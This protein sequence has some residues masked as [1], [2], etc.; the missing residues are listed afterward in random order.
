MLGAPRL[1]RSWPRRRLLPDRERC[2]AELLLRYRAGARRLQEQQWQYVCV[3]EDGSLAATATSAFQANTTFSVIVHHEEGKVSLRSHLGTYVTAHLLFGGISA[4]GITIGRSEKFTVI[5][6][7]DGELAFQSRYG[8]LVRIKGAGGEIVCDKRNPSDL[9]QFTRTHVPNIGERFPND[10]AFP[11]LWGMHD[12][13]DFDIDAPEAWRTCNGEVGAGVIVAVIDTGIDYNHEDLRGQ[14]WVNPNEIPDNG[15]DDDGNGYI[16]DIHGADFANDDGDPWDDGMHG[17]HCSGTIAGI[18]NNGIGVTGVAW[19]GVRLMALKFLSSDGSGRT[20]DAA[21]AIDYAIAEGARIASNSWGG[22]GSNPILRMAIERAAA[23]GVLFV[24]AAGNSGTDNDVEPHFPSNYEVDNIISVASTTVEGDLSSFSCYGA[25]TVDVA[26]PGS[27]IFST[28]PNSQYKTLSGTSMATPHVSGLAALIW[29]YRPKLSMQ[30]VKEIIMDSVQ[31]LPSLEGQVLSKGLINAHNALEAAW[32]FQ[33]PQPP[34][35][36]P[37]AVAFQDTNPKMGLLSGVVTITTALDESDVE[38][39]KVFFVSGAGF[40]LQALGEQIPATGARQVALPINGSIIAPLFATGVVAVSGRQDGADMPVRAGSSAPS[41]DFEDFVMPEQGPVSVS[42]SGNTNSSTGLLSGTLVVGRA[43]DE[44]SVSHYNI[45]WLDKSGSRGSLA[46]KIS[47]IGF[48]APVCRGYTCPEVA[49]EQ[50]APSTYVFE[51]SNY[52]DNEEAVISCSGPARITLNYFDTEEYFDILSLG[53][54]EEMSGRTDEHIQFDF[55]EGPFSIIWMSD[56]DTSGGGWNFQLVQVGAEAK[57]ALDAVEPLGSGFEVVAAHGKFELPKGQI[58]DFG[59]ASGHGAVVD[60]LSVP[61][62]TQPRPGQALKSSEPWLQPAPSMGR[63]GTL[64]WSGSPRV[65][66]ADLAAKFGRVRSSIVVPGLAARFAMRPGIRSIFSRVLAEELPHVAA[67]DIHIV[68]MLKVS[69]IPAAKPSQGRKLTGAKAKKKGLLVEFEVEPPAGDS[70][71]GLDRIEA[72]LILLSM[73]GPV[74]ARFDLSLSSQLHA[75]GVVPHSLPIHTQ[76]QQ[77]QHL[78][79]R[80]LVGAKPRRMDGLVVDASAEESPI[81]EE[82]A[83]VVFATS[84]AAV[85]AT[86]IVFAAM[87]TSIK[88]RRTT[89]HA[90]AAADVADNL[91]GIKCHQAASPAK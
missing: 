49:M 16:D 22:G 14:M 40:R 57:F 27:Y 91:V 68:R 43:R 53:L 7:D 50:V 76:V 66:V 48:K 85:V 5:Y 86:G 20:S 28:V 46:G 61:I 34:V 60:T 9:S 23:A 10:P 41:T 79:P 38:Y 4:T 39:Y 31:L 45:Y 82:T 55:D 87:L 71:A 37:V 51:R 47:A 56:E 44:T 21:K 74:A 6:E 72:K 75:A 25:S 1:R 12:W 84:A 69:D 15:I 73:G 63:H 83:A 33:P 2:I 62:A 65:M 67:G 17:T 3:A 11:V 8:K 88:R 81:K 70:Q 58:V 89:C 35:H 80:L 26:A 29:M 18:G 32:A 90:E 30:Q 52:T 54:Q 77:P 19:R 59:D 24:A 13:G 78:G 42:W 64:V 36:A